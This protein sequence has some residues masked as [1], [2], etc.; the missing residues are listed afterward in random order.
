MNLHMF[1]CQIICSES[2]FLPQQSLLEVGDTV[3]G[4]GLIEASH[5]LMHLREAL[6][7][8]VLCTALPD[9]TKAETMGGVVQLEQREKERHPSNQW[10]GPADLRVFQMVQSMIIII[11]ISSLIIPVHTW[12]F[13]SRDLGTP[14]TRK[15]NGF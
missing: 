15:V 5:V 1:E 6:L 13:F 4:G 8:V 9:R 2:S 3:W 7:H 10:Y 14:L 11:I 12:V